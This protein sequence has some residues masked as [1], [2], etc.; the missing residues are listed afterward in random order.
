MIVWL[1]HKIFGNGY[2]LKSPHFDSNFYWLSGEFYFW[3]GGLGAQLQ[4]YQWCHP[5]AG[6]ERE[7]IGRKFRPFHSHRRWGRV[8]VAWATHL[9]DNIDA[10]N[11][12]LRRMK[13]ELNEL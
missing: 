1:D 3:I 6:E 5:K 13:Q 2:G 12:E 10:A 8:E 7:L 11:A 9:P 4:S